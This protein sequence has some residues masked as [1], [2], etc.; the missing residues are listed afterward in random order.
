MISLQTGS[1]IMYPQKRAYVDGLPLSHRMAMKASVH[2]IRNG[3]TSVAADG[4][5]NGRL[6]LVFQPP[7]FDE[8]EWRRQVESADPEL[9]YALICGKMPDTST[10]GWTCSMEGSCGS[11]VGGSHQ[12]DLHP[13]EEAFQP[14]FIPGLKARIDN[15]PNGDFVAWIGTAPSSSG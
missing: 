6:L 4:A 8:V 13:E 1:R 5:G 2:E 14:A 15:M 12:K 9:L 7:P 3:G 11:S 10:H